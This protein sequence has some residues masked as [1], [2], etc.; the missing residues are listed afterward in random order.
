MRKRASHID[1]DDVVKRSQDGEALNLL[2]A[3]VRYGVAYDTLLRWAREEGLPVLNGKLFEAD[4]TLWRQQRAGLGV[5]SGQSTSSR[6][7]RETAGKSCEY[8]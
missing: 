7:R 3:S 5:A 6:R 2:E 1:K 4:F 8:L